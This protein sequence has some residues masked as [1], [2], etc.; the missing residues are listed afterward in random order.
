MKKGF[1][2]L[3]GML[4]NACRE[5]SNRKVCATRC[6]LRLHGSGHVRKHHLYIIGSREAR[7]GFSL[8]KDE[9]YY[10]SMCYA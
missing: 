4:A 5:D 7:M 10:M 6:A 8:H 9:L 3:A 1:L 2:E